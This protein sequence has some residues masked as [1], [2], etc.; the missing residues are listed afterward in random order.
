MKRYLLILL[1]FVSVSG[2]AQ[3][4]NII[5][6]KDVVISTRDTSSSELTIKNSTR[7]INGFLKNIGGGKTTFKIPTQNEIA[8]LP[9]SLLA[10]YTKSQSDARYKHIGYSPSWEEISGTPS[11]FNTTYA[12]SN[13]LKDSIQERLRIVNVKSYGALGNGVA[14]D[15]AAIRAAATYAE[16]NGLTLY[17]P[18]GIYNTSGNFTSMSSRTNTNSFSILFGDNVKIKVVD[19]T[20]FESSSIRSLFFYVTNTRGHSFTI[21]GGDVEID[22]N[23]YINQAIVASSTVQNGSLKINCTSLKIKNLWSS[24]VSNSGTH[25]IYVAGNYDLV[26]IRNVIID[27]I[28][29]ASS[30]NTSSATQAILIASQLGKTIIDNVIVKNIGSTSL[31]QDCDGIVLRG[32]IGGSFDFVGGDFTIQNS[33]I[34]NSRGRAIKAQSS[35]VKVYNTRIEQTDLQTF[36]SVNSIDFQV[37]NGIVDGCTFVYGAGTLGSSFSSIAFQERVRFIDLVSRATNNTVLSKSQYDQF[38]VVISS[39]NTSASADITFYNNKILPYDTTITNILTRGFVEFTADHLLAMPPSSKW[40]FTIKNNIAYTGAYLLCH[41][42]YFGGDL[43]NK[44]QFDIS[45]NKNYGAGLQVFHPISGN[46]INNVR[47]YRIKNNIGWSNYLFDWTVNLNVG[48]TM[49]DNEFLVSVGNTTFINAPTGM[50][51]S[52]VAT[53]QVGDSSSIGQSRRILIG[54]SSFHFF[55]LA[56]NWVR[57]PTSL[58]SL[59]TRN[60]SLLGG[61][62]TWSLTKKKIDSLGAAKQNLITNPVTGTGTPGRIALW[63]S[64]SSIQGNSN[65]TYDNASLRLILGSTFGSLPDGVGSSFDPNFNVTT[66]SGVAGISVLVNDGTNNRRAGLF[67]DQ[68]NAVWGLSSSHSSGAIPFVL[69]VGGAE[70]LRVTTAGNIGIGNLGANARLEVTATTGEVFR[71]DAA[72]GAFRIVANQTGVNTQGIFSHT[73]TAAVS[74]SITASSL[75]R[76]GGTSTQALIADGSVQTLTS[77]TYVPTATNINNT[78]SITADSAQFTRVG[79]VVTVSGRIRF[80]N[81][82]TDNSQIALTLPVSSSFTNVRQAAGTANDWVAEKVGIIRARESNT[83]VMLEIKGLNSSAYDIYYT[84]AY[85]IL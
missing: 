71:A 63:G 8:S 33:Y 78:S 16:Q 19:T 15:R 30:L 18:S 26:D 2:A 73:G 11:N 50:P 12:L 6:G 55:S 4:P 45:D 51:A 77:G 79:N 23:N 7:N 56:N 58:S 72:G 81:A 66:P 13:D 41:T 80:T 22:G 52:G 31:T 70:R 38:A 49:P 67:V 53:I 54:D 21:T 61:Y 34:L 9:D 1:L 74:S 46:R 44:L 43:S 64:S 20:N 75:I 69:R 32:V 84:Y 65:L 57:Q 60:D 17:F 40:S 83:T 39:A 85:R 14:D 35:N 3:A 36:N 68:T 5:Y 76:S 42:G 25:A 10:R 48:S 29:R 59:L 62:T 47:K 28:S 37:G 24:S 82:L 27:S